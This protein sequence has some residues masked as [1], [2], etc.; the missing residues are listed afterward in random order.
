MDESTRQMFLAVAAL[1]AG[2]M[3]RVSERYR[4]QSMQKQQVILK[5]ASVGYRMEEAMARI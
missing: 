3:E 2:V 4:G 1:L 5:L